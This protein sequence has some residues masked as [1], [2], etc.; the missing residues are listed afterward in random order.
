[1]TSRALGSDML[2]ASSMAARGLGC[3][4]VRIFS[5]ALFR[6]SMSGCQVILIRCPLSW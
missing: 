5:K 6:L 1:M 3:A 2:R 4:A